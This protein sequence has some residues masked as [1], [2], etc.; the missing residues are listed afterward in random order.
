MNSKDK[1]FTNTVFMSTQ[2]FTLTEEC[3]GQL[4]EFCRGR[5]LNTSLP[6]LKLDTNSLQKSVKEVK[7]A[8]TVQK[9]GVI[10]KPSKMQKNVLVYVGQGT[11]A[12]KG[13]KEPYDYQTHHFILKK[14][15]TKKER[16][17]KHPR[18]K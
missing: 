13:S 3:L 12:R 17:P 1:R 6:A 10:T 2:P 8:T 16:I 4:E 15:K 14:E 9:R 18:K 5:S 7:G 11:K